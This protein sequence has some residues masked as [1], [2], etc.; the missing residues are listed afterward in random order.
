[1]LVQI[2]TAHQI[3]WYCRSLLMLPVL[4]ITSRILYATPAC[5]GGGGNRVLPREG[6]RVEVSD[7]TP[8]A[9]V[10]TDQNFPP[11]LPVEEGECLKILRIEDAS[12]QELA[13]AFLEVTRGFIVPVGS[14]VALSSVSHLALWGWPRMRVISSP[15]GRGS[16]PPSVAALKLFMGCRF[17]ERRPRHRRCIG[18]KG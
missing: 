3:R 10:I 14:V 2:G 12:P 13:L 8:V 18:C 6:E 9:F 17:E 1:V 7:L 15:P 11:S 4:R 16:E 5:R